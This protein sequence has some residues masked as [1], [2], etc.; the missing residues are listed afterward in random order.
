MIGVLI[1]IHAAMYYL[2]HD[3]SIFLKFA[4][5]PLGFDQFPVGGLR[6]AYGLLTSAFFHADLNHLIMNVASLLIFGLITFRGVRAI[7]GRGQKGTIIFWLI[8]FL[9]VIVGG[10]AQ[11]LHWHFT[12]MTATYAIGASAGVSAFFAAAGWVIGGWKRLGQFTLIYIVMNVLLV[13]FI[14][15]IAWAA[16]AGGFI[17]GAILAPYWL[18]PF[19]AGTSILR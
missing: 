5:L 15:Q 17:A 1:L 7:H 19:S 2:R 14:G 4:L 16:H 13:Y 11:W 9:G 18:K 8:Y 6:Q 12:G 3:I 10:L